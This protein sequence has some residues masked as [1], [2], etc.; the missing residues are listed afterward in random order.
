MKLLLVSFVLLLISMVVGHAQNLEIPQKEF[1]LAFS[2]ETVVLTCGENKKVEIHILKSKA[3]QK[4][5]LKMGLSSSL[6]PGLSLSFDPEKG[7][8]DATQAPIQ[9]APKPFQDN[10]LLS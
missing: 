8:V 10:I 2:N 4:S 1:T 5:K 3:Y 6:P 9:P 7:S